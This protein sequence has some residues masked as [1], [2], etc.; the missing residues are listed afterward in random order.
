MA[1]VAKTHCKY[2][3]TELHKCVV[4]NG[5]ITFASEYMLL[6]THYLKYQITGYLP[7]SYFFLG[8]R[9]IKQSITNFVWIRANWN[10]KKS[11]VVILNNRIY[12]NSK[13]Q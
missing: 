9:S 11:Q 8:F 5:P 1:L 12:L 10:G 4:I 7:I 3:T 13:Y 6:E 2:P